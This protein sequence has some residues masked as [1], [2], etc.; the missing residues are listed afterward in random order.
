MFEDFEI[1][2]IKGKT[3][4]WIEK[5]YPD[6]FIF[7][8]GQNIGKTWKEKLYS[9]SNNINTK[10]KCY[11]GKDVKFISFSK[12]WRIF[13]S[14]KC[15]ANSEQIRNKFIETNIKKWGVSN[16]MQNPLVKEILKNSIIENFG[17]D[18]ISKSQDIKLKKRENNLKKFGYEY[19]SQ[20]PEIK[21]KLSKLITNRSE[22]MN[23]I[24][25]RKNE[26]NIIHKVAK[27]NIEFVSAKHSIYNFICEKCND[28]FEISKNTLNDR[29]K[30]GNTICTSCNPIENSSDSQ[31]Q[32]VDFIKSKW[33]GVVE[34][35]DRKILNGSELDIYLPDLKLAFEFNGIFWHTEEFRQKNYHL[36]KTEHCE[37]LGIKLIHIW[38]DDWRDKRSII[39][40]RIENL[41]GTSKRIWARDCKIQLISNSEY[42][43]FVEKNHLQGFTIA[44]IR[45]GLFY[46]NELVSIMSFGR[47]RISLGY[48]KDANGW[49][50]LRFVN[51][52]GLSVVGGASKLFSYFIKNWNPE[53]IISYADRSWSS[54]NLYNRLGF[55]YI[56][57][58][59]PNYYYVKGG[60]RF[61]RFSFRKDILVKEGNDPN[62]SEY[63]IMSGLGYSRIWDS[64]SL[65]F[66]WDKI[67]NPPL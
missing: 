25:Q 5:N 62:M 22:E 17:V 3:E 53:K 54:G 63:Q 26:L 12:G 6:F 39:E 2:K 24:V 46:K 57:K 56:G 16:P 38:E 44:K 48:K 65:K 37:N 11:C 14:T 67:K 35:N 32:L 4:I 52:V 21:E 66:E 20:R 47:L 64:G 8:N 30:N 7:I 31:D 61:G 43:D 1:I 29:I 10:P 13:C 49:E 41:I 19:N 27:F 60:K 9:W 40:S 58:T 55:K 42:R 59:N 51:K 18:N 36:N 45:L 28:K 50:L 23:K 15:Q 33:S 34:I